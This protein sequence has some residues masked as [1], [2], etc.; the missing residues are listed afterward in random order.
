MIIHSFVLNV[1]L[2]AINSVLGLGYTIGIGNVWRFPYLVYKNGG[3]KFP[4]SYYRWG[5]SVHFNLITKCPYQRRW[6][7]MLHNKPITFTY[8]SYVAI[9]LWRKDF[10]HLSRF[11]WSPGFMEHVIYRCV[12]PA[13]RTDADLLWNPTLLSG[14]GDGTVRIG[15]ANIHLGLISYV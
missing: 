14:A 10:N 6:V 3:G 8:I 13:L 9:Y 5:K 2:I 15:R 1:L 7:G 12:L 4:L 11:S